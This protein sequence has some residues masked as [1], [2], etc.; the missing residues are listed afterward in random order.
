[1]FIVACRVAAESH[2]ISF[3]IKESGNV[4]VAVYD[5]RGKMLRE[6]ACGV[7][8]EAGE[9]HLS[10]DGLD[11]YGQ[12]VPPAGE[13]EWRL[14]ETPGFTREFLVNVGTNPGWSPFDVWP[15]NHIGSTRLLVDAD[16]NLYIGSPG[17]EGPPHLLK[18]SADGKQKLWSSAGKWEL[19]DGLIG[20][21]RVGQTLYLLFWDGTLRIV[22][23]ESGAPFLA[24]P[25]LKRFSRQPFANL[26]DASD[27][28]A[29]KMT[30]EEKHIVRHGGATMAL[31]GG[32]DF[33]VVTY[34]K[35][36]EVRFLWPHED[37]FIKTNSVRVPAPKGCCVAPDGRVFAVSGTSIV[38]VNSE[39]GKV[40]PIVNDPELISP[41]RIAFDAVN[42][43]LLVIQ[44]GENLDDVRRYHVPDGKLVAAYGRSAG[45]TY[46]VF[47]PLDWGSLSDIVADGRGG[48]FTV[49]EFPRRVA[50]F[51]GRE[52]HQLVAQW[53]GGMQWGALCALDPANPTTVYVFLDYKHCGQGKIDYTNR[54][55]TLTHLYDLPEGFS[56]YLGKE[57]HRNMFP[58]FGGQ[59]FWEVRHVDGE[60]FLV[61][62]GRMQ[63]GGAAVVKVDE[64][65]N[66]IVPVALLGVLNRNTDVANPP[67][68][69]LEALKRAGYANSKNY[70]EHLAFS[71]SDINHNG[72]IDND[73]IRLGSLNV[74][75]GEAHC[76]VDSQ[77][78]VY[79]PL[80]T[81][82]ANGHAMLSPAWLVISNEG[83]A[84]LP[85]W[86]WDHAHP[87]SAAYSK[88]EEAF[89]ATY[90]FGIFHDRDGG[91]YMVCN[92]KVDLKKPDLPPLTW[93]NNRTVA[94][95]FQ[96][97][98]ANGKLEWSVG[99]HTVSKDRPPGEFAQV[100]GIFGEA[101]DCL[102]VVDACDPATVWTRDG[103]FAGSL[104]GR[105]ANDGLPDIAYA[106]LFY[107]DN[108][109]GQI[110]ETPQGD[111]LWGAMSVNSTPIY[112]ISG[113]DNWKRQS[114]KLTL[115][116]PSLPAR[117]KGDGL[118]A[119]YF[120]NANLSGAPELRR[121]DADIWFGPMWGDH[122]YVRALRSGADSLAL[123]NFQSF[124]SA[125]WAGFFEP[126]LSENFTFAIYTYGHS[127]RDGIHG[128]KIR[129]WVN[130][131]LVI[132]QWD[133]V[134]Q[135]KVPA[136]ETRTRVCISQ[137]IKLNAGQLVPIKLEC[138]ADGGDEA[139]LHLFYGSDSIDLR[140]VPQ[141][142]LY[143][144]MPDA[145]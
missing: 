64:K 10:W 44:H 72:K 23:E 75:R 143:S 105:R 74:T 33:L 76:F 109:W 127:F 65:E 93:P 98:D 119:E 128:S 15:G 24:D 42:D 57:S 43:D 2:D 103:L 145:R 99:L 30:E 41:T 5:V 140:H 19:S 86:N 120:A 40:T 51:S 48:F 56:W 101:R 47:N 104:L 90:P 130:G 45:R 113:W 139:H 94:S 85:V 133:D 50:H 123:T 25:K 14:L 95:R 53:F 89:G 26:D 117:W 108:H 134:K 121:K 78:N 11:R 125:R 124:G 32:K 39:T 129:L 67:P 79:H 141:S 102:V 16:T 52:H 83:S 138:V 63:G 21:A 20:M 136:G 69:W 49:E 4:S 82:M 112:R 107:D 131:Q 58:N 144:K 17:A 84:T 6:L 132:D 91:T 97:W 12:P 8:M 100:R 59:S 77:W 71:W 9:Y 116:Q 135:E 142:L 13:Y 70:F 1:M 88:E 35:H 22:N 106:N 36:D 96:K 126:P 114:G 3:Q 66:R 55:W 118:Q 38:Q 37:G 29:E 27:P 122:Q 31:A 137:P 34:Q 111:V 61:N 60:T 28:D 115:R 81:S 80:P 46:G 62:N 73:E 54:T 110:L 68:W 92:A 18:M 7:K 87:A